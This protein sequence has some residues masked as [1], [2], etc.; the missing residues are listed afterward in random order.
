MKYDLKNIRELADGDTEFIMTMIDA[1][2]EEI[3]ES[4]KLLGETIEDNDFEWTCR[5]AHKLKPNFELFGMKKEYATVLR[6]ET[7]GKNKESLVEAKALFRMLEHDVNSV[8]DEL[9]RA[10][11]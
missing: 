3:P 10:Y 4:M 7:I 6:I 9:K 11:T 5:H 2:L 1:F 8:I